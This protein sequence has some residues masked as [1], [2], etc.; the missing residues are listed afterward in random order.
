MAAILD[1]CQLREV[2]K[3]WFSFDGLSYT[4]NTMPAYIRATLGAKAS[5]SMVLLPK[6]GVFDLQHKASKLT[7][8]SVFIKI[9]NQAKLKTTIEFHN[10]LL[11][12][13][14]FSWLI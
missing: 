3:Y 14:S 12:F 7:H 10:V 13:I 5:A 2:Q 4:A 11:H 6:A 1:S 9:I 8:F